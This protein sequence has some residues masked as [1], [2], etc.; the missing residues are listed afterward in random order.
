MRSLWALSELK[1][2]SRVKLACNWSSMLLNDAASGTRSGGSSVGSSRTC[3]C[4]AVTPRTAKP[5]ASAATTQAQQRTTVNLA[6]DL[7]DAQRLN[8]QCG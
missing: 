6:A 4:S 2:L 3:I 8:I 1:W 7:P 5:A